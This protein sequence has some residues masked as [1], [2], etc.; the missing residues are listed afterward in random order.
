MKKSLAYVMTA[1][2]LGAA[3]MIFPLWVPRYKS[4]AL[5]LSG[6]GSEYQDTRSYGTAAGGL[7]SSLGFVELML[8]VSLV[9]ALG[10][11]FFSKRRIPL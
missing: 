11:Y 1:I 10:V 7:M 4:R 2:M 3:I 8:L 5:T 9:L 6:G